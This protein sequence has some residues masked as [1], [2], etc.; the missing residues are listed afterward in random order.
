M[1]GK[2]WQENWRG[3]VLLVI[4]ECD[5]MLLYLGTCSLQCVYCDELL[6][7]KKKKAL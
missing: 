7:V 6:A 2:K 1:H 4:I 5:I 3:I